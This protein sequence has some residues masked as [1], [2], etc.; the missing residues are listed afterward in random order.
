M[1]GFMNKHN[2]MKVIE[3]WWGQEKMFQKHPSNTCT[4]NQLYEPTRDVV[5]LVRSLYGENNL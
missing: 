3:S 1:Y 5:T 4:N 2:K